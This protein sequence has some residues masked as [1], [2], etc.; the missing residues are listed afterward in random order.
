MNYG[1]RKQRNKALHWKGEG[2]IVM[3]DEEVMLNTVGH[4]SSFFLMTHTHTH[5]QASQ[6]D[7]ALS[8]DFHYYLHAPWVILPGRRCQNVQ[9]VQAE[10]NALSF[11]LST[12]YSIMI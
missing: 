2:R 3:W 10:N 11:S 7:R 4:N 6:R 1:N 9:T 8:Q 12:L 5:T